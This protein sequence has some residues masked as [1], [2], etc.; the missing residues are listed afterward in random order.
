MKHNPAKTFPDLGSPSIDKVIDGT[1]G[2]FCSEW[3]DAKDMPERTDNYLV[4]VREYE[5][6]IALFMRDKGWDLSD[7]IHTGLESEVSM[8]M[9]LPKPW[10]ECK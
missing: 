8:W 5:P 10:K 6:V 9:A 3:V 4:V 2:I 7:T 1:Y